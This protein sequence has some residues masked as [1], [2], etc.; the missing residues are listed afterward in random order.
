MGMVCRLGLV[1]GAG[2]ALSLSCTRGSPE[3]AVAPSASVVGGLPEGASRAERLQRA[4]D[5]AEVGRVHEAIELLRALVRERPDADVRERLVDEL[6]KDDRHEEAIHHL[7]EIVKAKPEALWRKY[8]LAKLCHWRL[9]WRT[10]ERLYHEILAADPTFADTARLADQLN[11]ERGPLLYAEAWASQDSVDIWRVA[12][13]STFSFPLHERFIVGASYGHQHLFEP[14]EGSHRDQAV[15]TALVTVSARATPEFGMNAEAG[16]EVIVD[17]QVRPTGSVAAYWN[18]AGFFYPRLSWW[19]GSHLESVRSVQSN[20][21]MHTFSASMFAN[22]G[23][24]V[25][26]SFSFTHRQVS[27]GNTGNAIYAGAWFTPRLGRFG[28]KIG[29]ALYYD[30]YTTILEWP[31]PYFTANDLLSV[32][33]SLIA[34][35]DWEDTLYA[36]AGY[37]LTINEGWYISHNPRAVLRWKISPSNRI[38]LEYQRTNS[39]EYSFNLL[40]LS[41]Q[42]RF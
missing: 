13:R 29:S 12:G 38:D 14:F 27:D 30:D 41:F 22:P 32:S 33:P 2:L 16:A 31:W 42:H 20:V 5:H 10:S 8:Q 3:P 25:E 24:L 18:V 15:E 34:T 28:L 36:E 39:G 6:V 17:Q 11:A 4:A 23:R 21:A 26:L 35:W 40:R 9:C 37:T 1:V 19:Y 7:R